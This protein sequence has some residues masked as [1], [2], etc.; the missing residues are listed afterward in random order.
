MKYS[1]ILKTCRIDPKFEWFL[2]SYYNNINNLKE[3]F[4]LIIVDAHLWYDPIGRKE[5][6]DKIVNNRFSYIHTEPKPSNWNGPSRKTK[7]N[8]FDAP[9]AINTGLIVCSGDYIIFFDDCTILLPGCLQYH[10]LASESNK[11]GS[12]TFMYAENIIMHSGYPVEFIMGD[13]NFVKNKLKNKNGVPR[14]DW[15]DIM[16]SDFKIGGGW[17]MGSNSSAY[18]DLLLKCNGSDEYFARYGCEDMDLGCRLLNAGNNLYRYP[19]CIVLEGTVENSLE[20]THNLQF[21]ART[22]SKDRPQEFYDSCLN[23]LHELYWKENGGEFMFNGVLTSG[24][25]T[26][27]CAQSNKRTDTMNQAWSKFNLQEA[28]EYYKKYNKF[29]NPNFIDK[30]PFSGVNIEDI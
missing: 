1:V 21:P 10:V 8:Y 20:K 17:W 30:C 6:V 15:Q 11:C 14:P 7:Y 16:M 26:P 18:F 13:S 12:G 4:E 5:M 3:E 22:F 28:R 27:S 9:G 23:K 29:K 25:A 19:L 2:D 24:S